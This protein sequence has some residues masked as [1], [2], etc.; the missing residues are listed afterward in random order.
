MLMSK[1]HFICTVF[2]KKNVDNNYKLLMNF[3]KCH[4]LQ[5]YWAALQFIFFFI[6]SKALHK[7]IQTLQYVGFEILRYQYCDNIVE[8]TIDKIWT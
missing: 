5:R 2:L 7:N 8:M 6:S 1:E 3:K 4:I